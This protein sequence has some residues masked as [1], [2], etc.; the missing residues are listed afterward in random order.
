MHLQTL[1]LHWKELTRESLMVRAQQHRAIQHHQQ[2]LLQKYLLKWKKYH[3]RCLGKMVRRISSLPSQW[4]RVGSCGVEEVMCPGDEGNGSLGWGGAWQPC[5]LR[6][7]EHACVLPEEAL[8]ELIV[9]TRDD[10][11][12][13]AC[14]GSFTVNEILAAKLIDTC[15]WGYTIWHLDIEGGLNGTKG[16]W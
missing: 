10:K 13:L 4:P 6:R 3:Q 9:L 15:K 8:I 5:A 11:L 12:G 1:F 16:G 2:H 14:V 7:Q